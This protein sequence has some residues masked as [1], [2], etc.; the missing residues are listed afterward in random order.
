M[1]IPVRHRNEAA[2]ERGKNNAVWRN[3]NNSGG[4]GRHNRACPGGLW[5]Q[6]DSA[7]Q[8]GQRPALRDLSRAILGK[9]AHAAIDS[10]AI[11]P[12]SA[13]FTLSVSAFSFDDGAAERHGR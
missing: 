10:T 6:L 12:L 2:A 4:V 7:Q 8:Q 13:L 9:R 11:E 5:R 1:L 3:Y